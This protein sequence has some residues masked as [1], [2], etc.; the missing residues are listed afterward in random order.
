MTLLNKSLELSKRAE[1][2]RANLEVIKITKV[3]HKQ[4]FSALNV[5]LCGLLKE[6][7]F[8]TEENEEADDLIVQTRLNHA[9][10]EISMILHAVMILSDDFGVPLNKYPLYDAKELY[11][12]INNSWYRFNVKNFL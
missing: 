6:I 10:A 7:K 3:N 1:Q 12:M 9:L 2:A 5:H 11:D 4:V 8:A